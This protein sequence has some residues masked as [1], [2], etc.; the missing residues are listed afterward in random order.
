ML[1]DFQ[2][3]YSILTRVS[4]GGFLKLVGWHG[5]FDFRSRALAIGFQGQRY[6]RQLLV[7]L[8]S[9]GMS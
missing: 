8:D 9:T 4:R 1:Q 3:N 2:N 5:A 6:E 7:G